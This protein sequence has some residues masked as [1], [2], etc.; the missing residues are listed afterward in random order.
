MNINVTG[1][2]KA[3]GDQLITVI[4]NTNKRNSYTQ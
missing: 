1:T 4:N 2:M 3:D